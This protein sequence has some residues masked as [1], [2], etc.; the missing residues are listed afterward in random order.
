MSGSRKTSSSNNDQFSIQ[1]AN[2]KSGFMV[3]L[4]ALPLC[5]GIASASEC[6]P[7]AGIYTAIVGGIRASRSAV[8]SNWLLF[9]RQI[10]TYGLIEH[11][12]IIVDLSDTRLV[13]HTVMEKLH[14]LQDDF[15]AQ[16]LSLQVVGL[17]SH[18]SVSSHPT[19]ARVR[20]VQP[21]TSS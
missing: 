6:P 13:D 7:I 14:E 17:E 2:L 8:F 9:R 12:N 20:G 10:C 1:L 19:S 15:A 16:E 3:F 11:K 18:M 21:S 4:I 5:L